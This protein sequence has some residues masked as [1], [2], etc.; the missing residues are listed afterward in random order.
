MTQAAIM[1]DWMQARL[2][3]T[4]EHVGEVEIAPDEVTPLALFLSLGTQWRHAHTGHVLGLDY[5]VVPA[6]AAMSDMTMTPA[7]FRDLRLME[8]A[9]LAEF[10]A[11]ASKGSR[12]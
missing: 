10:T 8:G 11:A 3:G 5:G 2:A 12:A 4:S 1:P 9:A 7:L 6:V